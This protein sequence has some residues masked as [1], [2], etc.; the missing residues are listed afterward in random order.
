MGKICN[1]HSRMI[2]FARPIINIFCKNLENR[3]MGWKQTKSDVPFWFFPVER[4]DVIKLV[5]C[6]IEEEE[7]EED[8][9]CLP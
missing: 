9:K 8:K 2:R 1:R 7:E 3:E 6:L 4:Y 5:D